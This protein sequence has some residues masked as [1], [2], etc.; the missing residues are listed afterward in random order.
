MRRFP[1]ARQRKV[2]VPLVNAI[3]PA[4]LEFAN[5][6]GLTDDTYFKM[7]A[8]S[9]Y[10]A[11]QPL[12]WG[13]GFIGTSGLTAPVVISC[14]P[15]SRTAMQELVDKAASEADAQIVSVRKSLSETIDDRQAEEHAVR[16]ANM[17]ARDNVRM[18]ETVI[19]IALRSR[20]LGAIED[21]ED[22]LRRL[23]APYGN[24]VRTLLANQREMFFAASPALTDDDVTFEQASR[25]MPASTLAWMMPFKST[26][27]MDA[28]GIPIGKDDAGGSV[29]I[30][31]MT[32]T[33][34]RKNSNGILVGDSGSGKSAEL[35]HI[36]LHEWAVKGAKVLW[37]DPEGE[38]EAFVRKLG[39]KV[40]K[41][42][43]ESEAGI[44]IF[45]PR[46]IGGADEGTEDGPGSDKASAFAAAAAERVL[47]ATIPF[48]ASYIKIAFEP[49]REDIPALEEALEATYVRYG[50]TPEM[51]FGEYDESKLSYPV[52]SDLYDE[53][54]RLAEEHPETP[55]YSRLSKCI[56]KAAVGYDSHRYN[57]RE[58]IDASDD[59]VLINTEG[60][61]A[62]EAM[63]RAEYFNILSWCWS[64]IR[65]ERFTGRYVRLVADEL[66]TI[67]N[68][69]S[70]DAAMMVK[71]IV[72]RARKYGAGFMGSTPQIVDFRAE[73]VKDAG[74]SI[75]LN[76]TYR[77]Y[78][79]ARG[80][81]LE[82][83][84]QIEGFSD[85]VSQRLMRAQR[86]RF[87][88]CAGPSDKTWVNTV[89][90][91]WELALF[92]SGGGK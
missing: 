22:Y 19:Y 83:I 85:E 90:P 1:N 7:Y 50:I 17:I 37:I 79:G 43:S 64:Q 57:S 91:D 70:A 2:N 18:F 74:E 81:N 11:E 29:R 13:A 41:I 84:A 26:G 35:K 66:H 12:D 72:Q 30:D 28:K 24:G 75:I 27:L 40:V 62:D 55:S 9:D 56:R 10:A 68:A 63:M 88:L 31:T 58:V 78:G 23:L 20:E 69:K 60:I 44:P 87:V 48:V 61:S 82:S 14:R 32:H 39:C 65:S 5:T 45:A 86:A 21:L 3:A 77:F 6:H 16:I 33:S 25:P 15:A 38:A 71:N 73:K 4:R 89:I 67:V 42:G 51:T 53:L 46:N 36:I 52:M 8:M 59:I 47:A 54:N 80:D 49:E 92:G 76:S 34:T